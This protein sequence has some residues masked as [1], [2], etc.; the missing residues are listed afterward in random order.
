MYIWL[1]TN[2]SRAY[3]KAHNPDDFECVVCPI[4]PACDAHTKAKVRDVAHRSRTA[5]CDFDNNILDHASMH[6]WYSRM[7]Q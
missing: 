3:F 2:S 7:N 5:G 4:S 1:R 6:V